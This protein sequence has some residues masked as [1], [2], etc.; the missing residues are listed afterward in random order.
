M[1]AVRLCPPTLSVAERVRRTLASV[2]Y[3][4]G[5]PAAAS[6]NRV[7][8]YRPGGNHDVHNVQ[9]VVTAACIVRTIVDLLLVD[10]DTVA[11]GGSLK[12]YP[13]DADDVKD[14]ALAVNVGITEEA[15]RE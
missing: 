2:Q 12:R 1:L 4:P 14:V 5:L 8:E 13:R 3:T 6:V 7:L 9:D 11:L 15:V 10:V